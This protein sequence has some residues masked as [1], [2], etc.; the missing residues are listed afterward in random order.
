MTAVSTSNQ[1]ATSNGRD[2]DDVGGDSLRF[3]ERF[4]LLREAFTVEQESHDYISLYRVTA[5]VLRPLLYTAATHKPDLDCL[6]RNIGGEFMPDLLLEIN[7]T[8]IYYP[9]GERAWVEEYPAL[10]SREDMD[11]RFCAF[12]LIAI[13]VDTIPALAKRLAQDKE[14][15]IGALRLMFNMYIRA[16]NP[17]HVEDDKE[18]HSHIPASSSEPKVWIPQWRTIISCLVL[19]AAGYD[20]IR[21]LKEA[22]H[23]VVSETKAGGDK[24]KVKEAMIAEVLLRQ[25]T[26]LQEKG[27]SALDEEE[28]RTLVEFSRFAVLISTP[29]NSTPPVVEHVQ[30]E[31]ETRDWRLACGGCGAL[32]DSESGLL[33]CERCKAQSSFSEFENANQCLVS[34]WSAYLLF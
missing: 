10:E 32:R 12:H 1:D 11:N 8:P 29:E 19:L 9:T 24:V 16:I 13:M 18:H 23:Q 7:T 30:K 14:F 17:L 34:R 20:G 22:W 28:K 25:A 15:Q 6:L 21:T 4:A 26:V 2:H 3:R 5:D 33:K 27:P 31:L